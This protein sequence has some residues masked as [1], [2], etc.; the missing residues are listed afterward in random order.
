MRGHAKRMLAWGTALAAVAAAA[1]LGGS[2]QSAKA[3]NPDCIQ[4]PTAC[5]EDPAEGIVTEDATPMQQTTSS[6]NPQTGYHDNGRGGNSYVND[7]CLDPPPPD[8][9]R[10]VQSETELAVLN[11]PSS[12]GKK[13]VVGYNDS[14][15]AYDRNNGISGFSYTVNGGNT[16]ID[17]GG[18]PPAVP[19]PGTAV[20]SGKDGY[21]GDPVVIVHR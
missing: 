13:I 9:S 14:F 1:A 19:R 6:D 2:G 21:F 15:G 18:L 3:F 7:P 10:T 11:V 20:H 16:W 4:N 12:M 17:G 8:Q 5:I